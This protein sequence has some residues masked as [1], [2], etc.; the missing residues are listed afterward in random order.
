MTEAEALVVL[1]ALAQSTRLKVYLL[2]AGHPDAMPSGDVADAVGIPRN[3]MSA[4]LAILSKAGL[5]AAS[6]S[7]REVR[8]AIKRPVLRELSD[9]LRTI[10][11]G[12]RRNGADAC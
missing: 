4:H 3:L 12:S 5:I 10:D 11:E 9:F 2:L 7:G 6:K 1:N 8:Y